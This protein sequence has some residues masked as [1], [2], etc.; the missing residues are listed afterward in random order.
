M[1]RTHVGVISLLF[2]VWLAVVG[3][4]RYEISTYAGGPPASCV[5]Q[6]LQFWAGK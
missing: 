6:V 1:S 5:C 3:A 2:T 4:Q